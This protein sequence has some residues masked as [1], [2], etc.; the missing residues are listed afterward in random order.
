MEV[1]LDQDALTADDTLEKLENALKGYLG[2]R[3]ELRG[4]GGEGIL[5]ALHVGGSSS[6]GGS[7]VGYYPLVVKII[8]WN[9]YLEKHVAFSSL[10]ITYD[11]DRILF[12]GFA[13]DRKTKRRIELAFFSH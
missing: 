8:L 10:S 11:E 6:S 2:T 9:N 4:C 1:F 3:A 5:T 7:Y 12:D 13:P